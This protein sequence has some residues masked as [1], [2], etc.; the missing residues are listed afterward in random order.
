MAVTK[1][2]T[3]W[4]FYQPLKFVGFE[5]FRQV[6]T[7]DLFRISLLNVFKFV[8]IIVPIQ[9]VV[10]FLFAHVLKNLNGGFSSIA[11][12][13]I[14][15]PTV[16]SGVVAAVI[17]IFILD[18]RAG[19]LN[20]ALKLFGMQKVAFLTDKTLST[21]AIII[22]SIWLGFGSN[23]LI[24]YAGLLNIPKEYYEAAQVDGANAFV[25]LIKITIPS[26]KNIFVLN[27]IGLVTGTIQMFD[28]PFIMT[29]GGPLNRT[30][31]PM[32]FLFNKFRDANVTMGFT[33]AGALLMMIVIGVV[34]SFVF[35]IIT[36][37]KSQ[38]A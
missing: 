12:V 34:N 3:N 24:L 22:P 13:S 31:T 29:G 1:S 27:A 30:L 11:K 25:Q 16:I 33:L 5:N 15:I 18:Y 9:M 21:L 38:D 7:S 37:E 32:I 17:F 2:F 10:C 35:N 8:I 28:L 14:Y 20:E 23:T 36:S 26:L 19:I 4:N 6:I